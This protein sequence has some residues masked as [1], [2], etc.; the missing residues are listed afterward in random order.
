MSANLARRALIVLAML[1]ILGGS[2]SSTAAAPG[3]AAHISHSVTS[4]DGNGNT[5]WD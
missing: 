3:A 5:P 4:A 1:T 2:A